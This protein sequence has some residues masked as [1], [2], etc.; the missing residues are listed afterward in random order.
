MPEHWV[1]SPMHLSPSTKS[2]PAGQEQR[3]PPGVLV[4]VWLHMALFVVHSSMSW[5]E[6]GSEGGRVGG[7]G[8]EGREGEGKRKTS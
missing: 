5:E 3:N 8:V 4:H 2:N 7:R 1:S 6:K